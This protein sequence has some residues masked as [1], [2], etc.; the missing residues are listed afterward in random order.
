M[1]KMPRMVAVLGATLVALLIA[2]TALAQQSPPHTF[3]GF[4]GDTMMDGE[5]AGAGTEIT[6][7]AGGESVGSATVNA[8]GEWS[9]D[10]DAGMSGVTFMVGGMM[11]E[12]SYDTSEGGST[13]V[14]L[15]VTTPAPEEPAGMDGTGEECPEEDSL[16]GDSMSEEDSLEGDSMSEECPDAMDGDGTAMTDDDD[17]TAMTDGDDDTTMTDGDDDTTMMEGADGG[18]G[19]LLPDTGTGGLADRGTSS[20]VYGGIAGSL[21]LV[22]LLAGGFAVRRR[23]R[24]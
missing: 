18:D 1:L 17:S 5:N 16:E 10:L 23:V 13:R 24:S 22:A 21:A 7:M 20:A 11:A 8:M 15:A 6:A 19:S 3:Y 2:G 4:S 12:G 14:T 9:L